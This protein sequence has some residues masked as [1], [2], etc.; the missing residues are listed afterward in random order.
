VLQKF[1]L[2][3]MFAAKLTEMP[4]PDLLQSLA[5]GSKSGILHLTRSGRAG[6]IYIDQGRILM[7]S[8]KTSQARRP[9]IVWSTGALKEG[10]SIPQSGRRSQGSNQAEHSR[11]INGGDA[12]GETRRSGSSS[13]YPR[14]MS[15][16]Q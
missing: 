12:G 15:L 16:W 14:V 1:G 3:V 7:R 9:S 2:P 11:H 5:S 8:S 13:S 4:L 6:I 10:T